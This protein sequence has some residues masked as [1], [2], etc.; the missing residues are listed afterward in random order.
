V[1]TARRFRSTRSMPLMRN[2]NQLVDYLHK[3]YYLANDQ[4]Y[5]VRDGLKLAPVSNGKKR[6]KLQR[7]LARFKTINQYVTRKDR[8][9]SSTLPVEELPPT[10]PLRAA[11]GPPTKEL[12]ARAATDSVLNRIRRQ[13]LTP[14]EQFQLARRNAFDGRY[15]IARTVARRLLENRPD[16]HDVRLLLG[17]TYAWSQSFGRA[18]RAFREVLRRDST[19]RDAYSALADAE[20]WAA[21]P[22]TA[23]Q[24]TREGL[25][26]HPDWPGLLVKKAQAL[27]A[28]GRAAEAR[29]VVSELKR[30]DPDNTAL[31]TLKE[32]SSP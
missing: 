27:L 22:E 7:R 32:R 12:S 14:P 16:Y 9:Y 25:T 26:H 31:P 19:Y 20:L 11:S 2:K 5:R 24:V 1:D 3:E 18:R 4:L 8:L 30:V 23:L 28:M 15:G 13:D 10:F 6:R 21:R 17:R 29:T